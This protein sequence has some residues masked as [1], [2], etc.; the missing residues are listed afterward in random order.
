MNARQRRPRSPMLGVL[1]PAA[2]VLAAAPCGAQDRQLEGSGL[3]ARTTTSRQSAWG[4]GAQLQLTW[5][6]ERQPVRLATGVGVDW[7]RQEGDGQQQTN[8]SIDVTLQFGGAARLTPYLGG[9]VGAVWTS[10]EDEEG[11]PA[12]GLQGI[13]GA[14]LQLGASGPVS[15]LAELLHGYVRGQEHATGARLGISYALR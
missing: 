6:A 10:G 15:L 13:A 1:V 3:Y 12:L 5:G 9:S 11:G 7:Q 8:A 2:L 4:A 14:Q